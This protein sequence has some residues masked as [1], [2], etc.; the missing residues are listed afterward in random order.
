MHMS[1]AIALVAAKLRI[2]GGTL[3]VTA[4]DVDWSNTIAIKSLKTMTAT[5][6]IAITMRKA[7]N[8]GF[9]KP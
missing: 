5:R 4:T 6:G 7:A 9:R 3:T 1:S 8:P 2:I